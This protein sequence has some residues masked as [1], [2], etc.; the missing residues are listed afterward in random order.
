MKLTDQHIKNLIIIK[1]YELGFV[2]IGF[3]DV[4]PL[5]DESAKLK[6]WFDKGYDSDMKWIERSLEKR[7]D[8][9]KVL[10]NAKTVISLAYNY[11]TPLKH[12]DTK[13]KISRYAW[14]KDYHIILKRKLKELC[15]F[16]DEELP[17]ETGTKS[18]Y[19]ADD[20][21][22]M[23]KAWAVGSGIGWLGKHTNVITPEFGSWVFLCEIITTLEINLYDKPIE[24]LCGS[25][26]ICIDACPTGAIVNEY[27]LDSN[28]CISYQTIE[29]RK[30]IPGQI[31]L[32]G[33]IF[34]CD[35]CQDVCPFNRNDVVTSDTSFYPKQ[36]IYNKS[37]DELDKITED[38]FNTIFKDSPVKRT[39]YSGWK[40]NLER[41][42]E[43][44]LYS[45][46]GQ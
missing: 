28:L 22:V 41:Y 29:N 37:A 44:K 20:G 19:Y 40:R 18:I 14:G 34:G 45:N 43:E 9:A 38:E 3:S 1:S 24:D 25:C 2:K 17:V 31:N 26:K 36:E 5:P 6:N 30:E 16:I 27:L 12:D 7:G 46:K 23:E 11:F 32:Q 8:V 15:K 33:W 13:P 21:P 39:K 42:K 35:I 10:K 4:V